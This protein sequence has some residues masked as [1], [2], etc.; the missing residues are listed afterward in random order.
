MSLA[1]INGR[2][3]PVFFDK[4]GVVFM[5][6]NGELQTPSI[7][8][9]SGLAIEQPVLG[10]RAPAMFQ[11]LLSSLEA[12]N[13]AAPEL[14]MAISEI[15]IAPNGYNSF[16]VII[17]PVHNAVRIRLGMDL[18]DENMLRYT[19]L[20]ADVCDAEGIGELDFRTGTAAYSKERSGLKEAFSGG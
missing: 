16:D 8:V 18:F 4:E 9:V 2:V 1:L 11:G 17:Y 19:I 6:G 5:I 13:T 10:M 12:I 14:M 3:S 20:L 7:P 15:V